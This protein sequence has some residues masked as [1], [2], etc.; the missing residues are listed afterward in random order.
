MHIIRRKTL[1]FFILVLFLTLL[2]GGCVKSDKDKYDDALKLL[3]EGKLTEASAIFTELDKYQ[4]SQQYIKF[5][6]ARQWLESGDFEAAFQTLTS[7]G[8]FREAQVLLEE[9]YQQ[10]LTWM[11]EN[12]L[13]K[14]I[15][16]FENLRDYSESTDYLTYA[17]A[18]QA[19]E[20]DK[21][22][23]A[24][25]TVLKR[26]ANFSPADALLTG[27]YEQAI[28]MLNG[29][30]LQDALPIFTALEDYKDSRDYL[31]YGEALD[32]LNQGNFAYAFSK[33]E[34]LG[35]FNKANALLED[36]YQKAIVAFEKNDFRSAFPLFEALDDYKESARYVTYIQA[37]ESLTAGELKNAFDKL[38]SLGDFLDAKSLLEEHYQEAIQA[39]ES[40]NNSV[41]E[42]I[43]SALDD[44][45][46]SSSYLSLTAA[47]EELSNKNY[48]SAVWQLKELGAFKPAKDLLEKT[49]QEAISLAEKKS[50]GIAKDIFKALDY[51]ESS[52]YLD[53]LP[54]LQYLDDQNYA[55]AVPILLKLERFAPAAHQLA[56]CHEEANAMLTAED[57][58]RAYARFTLLEKYQDSE[59][60]AAYARARQ[61]LEARMYAKGH[62]LLA[63]LGDFLNAGELTNKYAP[64]SEVAYRFAQQGN[65]AFFLDIHGKYGV[66]NPDNQILLPAVYSE[67]G[68]FREGMARVV[69]EEYDLFDALVSRKHG[70]VNLEGQLIVPPRYDWAADFDQG[71]SKVFLGSIAGSQHEP[72]KGSFGYINLSGIEIIPIEWQDIS[73]FSE[74]IA[75]IEKSGNKGYIHKNGRVIVEPG[76]L[77]GVHLYPFQEGLAAF[78]YF[79]I[80]GGGYVNTNGEIAFKGTPGSPFKEGFATTPIGYPFY[81]RNR[82]GQ[83]AFGEKQWSDVYDFN[84]GIARVYDDPKYG[85][86][87]TQGEYI[88]QPYWD[89]AQDF[90]EG[91]AW[92]KREGKWAFINTKGEL[93]SKQ[94]WANAMPFKN[95]V[96]W[97]QDFNKLWGLLDPQDTIIAPAQWDDISP[98]KQGRARVWS[99]NS[100]YGFVNQEGN[101]VTSPQWYNAE[102]FENGFAAVGIKGPG[103]SST[104]WGYIDLSGQLIVNTIWDNAKPFMDDV[105]W[106]MTEIPYRDDLPG[107]RDISGYIN[108]QGAMVS[109]DLPGQMITDGIL[110]Y[111]FLDEMN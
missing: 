43:F 19:L 71:L 81:Y 46:L 20:T 69:T 79:A 3:Q 33:L 111:L 90:S 49:Y 83:H 38:S 86:I 76:S 99:R 25:F 29:K 30:N 35:E 32:A 63:S 102:S 37:K 40:G 52:Q 62:A 41:A 12:S 72:K 39:L 54:A 88:S 87:N 103:Y 15:T 14:A 22:Y 45:Q 44:Y 18:K 107:G 55:K 80:S 110:T 17:R 98:F 109:F 27:Y 105:A 51:Q 42:T 6:K 97:V 4:D 85:F 7:L 92:V 78:A 23:W 96:A 1:A 67:V 8:D 11:Q 57:Y 108:Q 70:F 24:G 104:L 73:T 56:L 100:G 58:G 34:Q 13:D 106:V 94:T 65:M 60:Y 47:I 89:K 93:I 21:D 31:A 64:L 53:L 95:G 9:H 61:A 82:Q 2:M 10:G 77:G 101:L 5:I 84:G 68:P 75:I 26:Q 28:D 16:R 59:K 91:F 48:R 36:H 74:D 50:Y 66:M